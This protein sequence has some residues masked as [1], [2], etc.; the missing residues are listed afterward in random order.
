MVRSQHTGAV[1]TTLASNYWCWNAGLRI[2][3]LKLQQLVL[4]IPLTIGSYAMIHRGNLI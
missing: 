3:S 4:Y 1:L 2:L